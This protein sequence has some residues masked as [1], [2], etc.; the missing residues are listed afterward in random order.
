MHCF[1]VNAV[2]NGD[3]FASN[4]LPVLVSGANVPLYDPFAAA[5]FHGFSDDIP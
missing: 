4:S 1:G 5:A 3:V 2:P